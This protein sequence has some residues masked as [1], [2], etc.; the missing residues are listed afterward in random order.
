MKPPPNDL[1]ALTLKPLFTH[2][3]VVVARRGHALRGARSLKELSTMEWASLVPARSDGSPVKRLFTAAHLTAPAEAIHCESYHLFVSLVAQSPLL[4]LLT[5]KLM[6][7]PPARDYLEVVNVEEALPSYTIYMFTRK[8]IP[9]GEPAT[10]LTR[11]V[12]WEARRLGPS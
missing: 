12:S 1:V 5:R 9:L 10:A 3:L 11:A 2:E 7:E 6:L 4:G 8:G